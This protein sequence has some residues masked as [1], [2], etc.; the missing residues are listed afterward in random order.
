MTDTL[1]PLVNFLHEAGML[2]E[3]PRSGFAFLGSGKQSVA[4]HSYRVAL[5]AHVLASLFSQ[6]IDKYKLMMLCLLHDLPESRIG[7]LNYVQKK[8]VTAH[9]QKALN[10]IEKDSV[11]GPEV[12]SWIKE[13][14]EGNT[15]EAKLAHDADQLELLL[16][17]KQ[18]EE[19]GNE[20]AAEW[21]KNAIKRLITDE[22]KKMA[23]AISQTPTDS[24]WMGDRKDSHWIHGGKKGI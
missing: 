17:L 11:L 24:W 6:K 22:A 3:I 15:L 10:D 16:M 1:V 19:K 20:R 4:E 21:Y 7:D 5:T 12:V 23:E 13:Y 9:T 2:A 14:E 8:Y 18:E